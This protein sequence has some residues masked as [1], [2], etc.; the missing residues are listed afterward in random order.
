[1]PTEWIGIVE[2]LRQ[3]LKKEVAVTDYFLVTQQRI[4]E[5]AE[6]SQDRQWIHVDVDRA[7]KE[8]PFGGPIAHGFLT[9]STLGH[10]L[11]QAVR[12][13]GVRFGVIYGLNYVRFLAVVPVGSRIRARIFLNGL[14]ETREFL[15]ATWRLTVERAG[16]IQPPCITE[17]LV[18]Y[19][20]AE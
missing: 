10:L 1:M 7:V 5:F 6:A 20:F 12:I 18:R 11:G 13:R 9:L 4:N 8:S 17:W 2:D 19:Y 14:E 15:E 3:M 16:A